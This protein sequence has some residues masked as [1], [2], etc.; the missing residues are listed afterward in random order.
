VVQDAAGST[1]AVDGSESKEGENMNPH[2]N[3]VSRFFSTMGIPLLAG[4]DFT[5][6]DR[7][8]SPRVAVVNEEFARYFYGGQSP[9]GRRFSLKRDKEKSIEIVGLVKDGE[10]RPTCARRR[11]ASSTRPTPRTPT[12]AA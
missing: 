3:G 11:S 1:V 8:D 5:D 6:A 10:S 7:L 12:W 4:R 9:I 2:F